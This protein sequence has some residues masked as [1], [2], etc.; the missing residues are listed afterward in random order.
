MPIYEKWVALI[1]EEFYRQG[2][3]ERE[4]GLQVSPYMDRHFPKVAKCQVSFITFI[5][6]P[7][8][9]AIGGFLD[10]NDLADEAATN[11]AH[12]QYDLVGICLECAGICLEFFC[13]FLT[14]STQADR[15]SIRRPGHALVT[16][17][18]NPVVVLID[19]ID[20]E[21]R[22]RCFRPLDGVR[23]KVC[24]DGICCLLFG[25]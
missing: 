5:C 22:R 9:K 7:T 6:M 17:A 13:R 8:Y 18:A 16:Q 19:R 20:R 14:V 11:L 2:D 24:L 3:R 10:R 1:M 21:R 23:Q 12:W 4:A 15:T 25:W